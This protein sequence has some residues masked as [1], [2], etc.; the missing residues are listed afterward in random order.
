MKSPVR[1]KVFFL[2]LDKD[3]Q[4]THRSLVAADLGVVPLAEADHAPADSPDGL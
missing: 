4:R 3:L 2:V 1:E